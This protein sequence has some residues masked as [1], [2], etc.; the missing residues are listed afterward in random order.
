MVGWWVGGWVVGSPS[1]TL[2]SFPSFFLLLS[3]SSLE[4][5]EEGPPEEAA[6]ASS[7][8][9]GIAGGREVEVAWKVDKK[10]KDHF[11]KRAKKK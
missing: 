5:G 6:G 2:S 1:T 9:A 7:S 3:F 11:K 10:S 4:V 8:L